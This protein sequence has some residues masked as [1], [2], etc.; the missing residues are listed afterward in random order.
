MNLYEYQGKE[1]F[2]QYR[3]PIPKGKL[4]VNRSDAVGY[5][6]QAGF[7]VVVK[8]QV[9]TGGRGKSGGI[10][11]VKNEAE[12]DRAVDDVFSLRIKGFAVE[13]VLIEEGVNIDKEIYMSILTNRATEKITLIACGQGGMDI[14]EV[15]KKDA[16]AVLKMDIDPLIGL[17]SH[18]FL[19][20]FR[21]LEISDQSVIYQMKHIAGKMYEMFNEL[22]LS[23]VEINPLIITSGKRVLA[24][25]SKTVIDD[26]GFPFLKEMERFA[27]QDDKNRD[28][29]DAKNANLSFVALDGDIGCI[30]NGAG[31]AM[32]TMDMIK[33]FGGD[34]ANFLDIG[35]SSN[36]DK[37]VN[38]LKIITRNPRVKAILFNIFGGITRCDDVAKGIKE[39]LL[40]SPISLPIVIRLTGTNQSEGVEILKGL[41]LPATSS[42]QE[43][44]KMAV[45]KCGG[46]K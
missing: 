17:R 8:A 31:L 3:I 4:A 39:A 44:V 35:G 34:P 15:A 27:N 23:L 42:M 25:D 22:Y 19:K 11:V 46:V 7:P 29:I 24:L 21:H 30:V 26:N 13:K 12:L 1:L 16:A 10:K 14:E 38:A 6:L 9:L 32:A 43:A 33:H 45:E 40:K 36:P 37:V 28:E 18:H 20:L 2:A 5:A 41:K